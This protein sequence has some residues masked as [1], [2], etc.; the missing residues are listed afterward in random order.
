MGYREETIRREID[1]KAY[2]IL[3]YKGLQP[4]GTVS[5]VT[6]QMMNH[7]PIEDHFEINHLV[8]GKRCAEIDRLAV[9]KEERGSIIPLGL[10]TLAYLYARIEGTESL[11]LDVFADDQKQVGMYYKLGFQRLGQYSD[12]SPV[13]VM[14]LDQKTEYEKKEQR[15]EHFVKPFMSRLVRLIDFDASEKDKFL[16][17]VETLVS[18]DVEEK[19]LISQ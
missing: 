5:V 16:L 8:E 14:I 10:M 9:L 1:E 6:T 7:I 11:F 12:P 18:S 19:E 13:E 2:H 4:V 3:A 17:A 15:M